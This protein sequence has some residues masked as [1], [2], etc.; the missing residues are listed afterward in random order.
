MTKKKGRT[1]EM[2]VKEGAKAQIHCPQLAWN[3]KKSMV[4][5]K[6]YPDVDE[7][8]GSPVGQYH[9]AQYIVAPTIAIGISATTF[10]VQNATQP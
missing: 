5:K 2:T 7:S 4:I 1:F 8:V 3:K 10:A 6:T 9:K